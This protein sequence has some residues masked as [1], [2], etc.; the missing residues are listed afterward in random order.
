M[1]KYK[2]KFTDRF[3]INVDQEEVRRRFV[4]RAYN[5]FFYRFYYNLTNDL[6]YQVEIDISS[7]LGDKY[8]AGKQL[9][10]YIGDDFLRTIQALEI[11]YHSIDW[12]Y[13]Y[14]VEEL[15]NQLIS[16]SEIDIGVRW[17]DHRFIR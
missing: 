3:N 1:G 9:E 13:K 12:G 14:K 6:R 15:I 4:N 16:E 2:M 17:I 8:T 5:K 10:K 7:G 11:L